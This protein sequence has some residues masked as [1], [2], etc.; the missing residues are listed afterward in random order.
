MNGI[1]KTRLLDLPTENVIEASQKVN[2]EIDS[3]TKGIVIIGGYDVIPSA[4]L[5]VLTDEM[6]RKIKEEAEGDEEDT[7][8]DDF[9]VWCDDIYGDTDND[10]LPELPVSRIPDGKSANLLFNALRAPSFVVEDKFGIRNI[11]RPFAIDVFEKIPFKG[12]SQFE[13]SETCS[14]KLVSKDSPLGA[15]Y[16]MLHGFHN[17]ATHFVGEKE[18]SGSFE[19]FDIYNV[20]KS[21]PGT[22]VFTGCC[23]GALIALPK[24]DRK[25]PDITLRSRTVEQSIALAFLQSSANAFI[26]CTGAHYSPKRQEDNFLGKP[27]HL[28]FWRQIEEGIQPSQALF[29]AKKEYAAR[30]PHGL[31][32]AILQAM[33]MKTL[34]Q[35]TCLG[36]GW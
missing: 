14:P 33:E 27:M 12:K 20:P 17:D 15:V 29:N 5:N 32:K 21:N 1:P 19:A 6:R 3:S 18:G 9:I 34:H 31:T 26:G 25:E 13:V 16:F 4:Q 7:D 22:V 10:F 24:A 8:S 36:L 11:K 23:Y 2:K 35:F 30:M 28:S